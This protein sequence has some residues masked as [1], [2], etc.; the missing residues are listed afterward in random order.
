[1]EEDGQEGCGLAAGEP[2]EQRQ[3]DS[4]ESLQVQAELS[5]STC[6]ELILDHHSG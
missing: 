1:M 3:T 5:K 6:H 2:A 4:R